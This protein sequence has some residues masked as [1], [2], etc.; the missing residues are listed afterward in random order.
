MR[1]EVRNNNVDR[2]L[3]VMKRKM[4]DENLFKEMQRHTF[5]EKPSEQRRRMHRMA[6]SRHKRSVVA[7]D[8]LQL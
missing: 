6:I 2:A 8:A 1:I 4:T 3:K 5:Y 7:R